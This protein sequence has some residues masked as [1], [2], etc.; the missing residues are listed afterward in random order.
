MY[1]D[2][3]NKVQMLQSMMGEMDAETVRQVLMRHN[4]DIE[5]AA[6]AMLDTKE[7]TE[8]TTAWPPNSSYDSI[9]LDNSVLNPQMP[10]RTNTPR[11]PEPGLP[12]S[13]EQD[14]RTIAQPQKTTDI[15]DLTADL[16]ENDGELARALQM[17]L[18]QEQPS[19]TFQPSNRAPDPNWAMV[20]SN[21]CQSNLIQNLF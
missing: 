6:T 18:E 11:L 3:D 21:V 2:I 19:Q 10:R 17:S 4:E 5:A 1:D 7:I 12:T 8:P 14:N 20:P 15:I 9:N 13:S 16:G